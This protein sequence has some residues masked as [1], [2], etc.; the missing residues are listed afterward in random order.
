LAR[1]KKTHKLPESVQKVL[2]YIP[3]KTRIILA[4]FAVALIVIGIIVYV[5]FRNSRLGLNASLD[6]AAPIINQATV[7]YCTQGDSNSVCNPGANLYSGSVTSNSVTTTVTVP[8][9]IPSPSV[10]PSPSPVASPSPS[11]STSP[12]ASQLCI[13]S[14][15]LADR[16]AGDF[17]HTLVDVVIRLASNNTEVATLTRKGS[18]TDAGQLTVPLTGVSLSNSTRYNV[19]VKP[20]GYFAQKISNIENILNGCISV[21]TA[22]KFELGDIA[23]GDGK[24]TIADVVATIRAYNGTFDETTQVVFQ[25][26]RATLGD[27]VAVIRAVNA[28]TTDP[29]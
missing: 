11:P 24:A 2:N 18:I 10:A 15:V 6:Q 8:S 29:Q 17:S 12:A 7:S 28:N 9:P 26:Q 5:Q 16:A 23:S 21:P 1:K 4:V 22:Q 20:A 14:I 19:V 13:S 3:A 27:I 25:G